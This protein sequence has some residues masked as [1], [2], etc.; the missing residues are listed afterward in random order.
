MANTSSII[1]LNVGGKKYD[2]HKDTLTNGSSF[3]VSMFNGNMQP[4]AKLSK[5]IFIDRDGHLFSYI[6]DYLRNMDQWRAPKDPDVLLGMIRESEF[7][8]IDGIVEK[9]KVSIPPYKRCFEIHLMFEGGG[10]GAS[11]YTSDTPKRIREY[12]DEGLAPPRKSNVY[13]RYD[14]AYNNV[15]TASVELIQLCGYKV[16]SQVQHDK[17]LIISAVDLYDEPIHGVLRTLLYPEYSK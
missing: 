15:I 17:F 14:G 13:M 1:R 16:C 11:S 7:F 12:L 8:G 3:F 6:L 9:I 4:G 10:I 2:A 5:R